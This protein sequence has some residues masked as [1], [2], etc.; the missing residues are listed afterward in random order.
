MSTVLLQNTFS[1]R[2]CVD[3]PANDIPDSH[4]VYGWL[5]GNWEL[6]VLHYLNDVRQLGLKGHAH[7]MWVL[8]GRAIQDLWILPRNVNVAEPH[9]TVSSIG[10]TLRVWEPSSQTW[11]VTWINPTTGARDELRGRRID[12]DIVQLGH[13]RDGTPIR[14]MFTEITSNSFRWTGEAMNDDGSWR[15]EAEFVARRV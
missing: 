9:K 11:S 15:L 14:W 8:E 3:A 5:L 13:H 7:F 1:E 4:N 12:D 10:T 6:D 2:L